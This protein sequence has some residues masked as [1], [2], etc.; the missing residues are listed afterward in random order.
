MARIA[1]REYG[2]SRSDLSVS[3]EA[4]TAGQGGLQSRL[5]ASGNC[6]E[7]GPQPVRF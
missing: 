4:R 7:T 5:A 3:D 6:D 2:R 1:K